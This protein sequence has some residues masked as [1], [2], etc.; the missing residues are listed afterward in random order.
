MNKSK[1]NMEDMYNDL[2]NLGRIF[3][4]E[5]KANEL[6]NKY[7]MEIQELKILEAG[8]FHLFGIYCL[9]VGVSTIFI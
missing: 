2:L 1:A 7:R 6:I 3:N 4:V 8:R 5:N 9:I